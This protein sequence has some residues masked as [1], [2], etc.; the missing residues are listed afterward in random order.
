ME[1]AREA[2]GRGWLLWD[3]AVK[4]TRAALVSAQPT[5][6]PNIE[7]Y[8][9]VLR[10]GDIGANTEAGQRT[11]DALRDDLRRLLAAGYYPVTLRQMAVER[12]SMVPAGKR[13]V[14]L[15]F[16]GAAAGQF[17]LL[18][19][20]SLDPESAVG[21]L[22]AFHDAHRADWPLRATFFVPPGGEEPDAA[23]FG[24]AES[25]RRK[26]DMLRS[27]GMEIGS[28]GMG[29]E[30]LRGKGPAEVQ[31]VLG[32]SQAL[33]ERWLP[34]ER[35]VS[36]A[37]PDGAFPADP[38]LA[39]RGE[40]EGVRYAYSAVAGGESGMAPSPRLPGFDPG[41]IPRIDVAAKGLDRWLEIAERPGVAYV[42][43]GE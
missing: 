20:G 32:Q 38:S 30:K 25:A 33:L 29:G 40:H 13:P 16:D 36:L 35:V 27:W 8:V 19:D 23:I 6:A 31:R 41:H 2:G 21:I 4:Y 37:L 5:S 3:P 14:V 28:Y 43:A 17:R 15:T 9:P 34:G 7:G 39:A 12:L 26:L 24:Q 18:P 22:K 1:G 11:P 10:Y 42:S